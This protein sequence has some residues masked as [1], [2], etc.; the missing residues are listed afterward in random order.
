MS[1]WAILS[2]K[3]DVHSMFSNG[4]RCFCSEDFYLKTFIC[5]NKSVAEKT[6]TFQRRTMA[7]LLQLAT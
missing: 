7:I 2:H 6:P 5:S 3:V 4:L 1:G